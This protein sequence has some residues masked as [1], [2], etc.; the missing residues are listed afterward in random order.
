MAKNNLMRVWAAWLSAGVVLSSYYALWT[1]ATETPKVTVVLRPQSNVHVKVPS[2]WGHWVGLAIRFRHEP[3]DHR[4]A[5]LGSYGRLNGHPGK[6]I[7]PNP[8][9]R[10]TG[11]V[12]ING[13]SAVALE[14]MPAGVWSETDITR[15]LTTNRSMALG[16]WNWPAP[17]APGI[18]AVPGRNDISF[19]ITDVDPSLVGEQVTLLVLPPLSFKSGQDHYRWLWYAWFVSPIGGL[20][21]GITGLSLLWKM[22]RA[23]RGRTAEKF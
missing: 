22:L 4:R 18:R 20:V 15:T 13:G 7:F 8:G 3:N 16:E 6:L 19:R 5:D 23:R 1:V 21:L 12:S 9:K 10:I 14:A 11:T 2:L 17:G